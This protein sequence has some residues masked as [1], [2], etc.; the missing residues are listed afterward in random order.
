MTKL[1]NLKH[2]EKLLKAEDEALYDEINGRIACYVQKHEYDSELAKLLLHSYPSYA[3]SLDAQVPLMPEGWLLEV[4]KHSD[5]LWSATLN[6]RPE[7]INGWAMK[8]EPI[9]RLLAIVRVWIWKEE[10]ES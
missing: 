5:G 8:T 1:E 9:A 2:V 10:N 6:N 7:K 4:F 3:T